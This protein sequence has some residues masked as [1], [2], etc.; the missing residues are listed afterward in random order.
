MNLEGVKISMIKSRNL[1]PVNIILSSLTLILLFVIQFSAGKLGWA[2]ADLFS[3]ESID[4]NGLFAR[5]SIHH[6]T[7]MLIALAIILIIQKVIQADFGFHLGDKKT[8][9]RYL[10]IFTGAFAVIALGYHI[11]M[12]I[13]KQPITYSYPLTTRNIIGYVGFQLLL[14]GSSEEILYRALPVTLLV[15]SFGKSIYV[16]KNITLEV[17][18]ASLLF[19]AAHIK[20][21]IPPFSI[22]ELNIFGLFYAFTMGILNGFVY[23]KSHSIVYPM[24]MHSI[25]NVLMVGTGYVFALLF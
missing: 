15:F 24:L 11:F 25:S 3:F 19:A 7:Q 16:S 21:S 4:P 5:L 20:W 10:F 23:Q 18:L 12:E 9:L 13:I 17:V 1:Y 6:L 14:S 2:A 8:G 22:L